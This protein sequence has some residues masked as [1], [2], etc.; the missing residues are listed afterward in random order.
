MNPIEEIQFL[1]RLHRHIPVPAHLEILFGGVSV[2]SQP[3]LPLYLE[4][5][6]ISRT[7]VE[8]WKSIRRAQRALVL[9][10]YFEHTL[11]LAGG[12]VECG[13]FRGFSA[14]LMAKIAHIH[15]PAFSGE[16]VHLIDS[17]EGLSAPTAADAVAMRTLETGGQRPI[18]SLEAGY[19]ATPLDEVEAALRD[20]PDITFHK[21]WIPPVLARVPEKQWAFVHLDV[22]LYEPTKTS[23]AYFFPRLAKGGVILNDD[24]KSPLFPGAGHAWREF[25]EERNLSYLVLDT[26]Q[27]V[28]T[29]D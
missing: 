9:V 4:A 1:D 21:G 27:A 24:F 13:V 23:L 17:F 20:Y 12:R 11:R 7:D 8:S 19:F 18:Y 6:R 14:L 25:F 26:G 10:R 29:N 3:F 15:D 5:M 16:D 22:D 2:G 28:F